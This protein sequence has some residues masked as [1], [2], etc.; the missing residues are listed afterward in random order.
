MTKVCQM[1]YIF[2]Y[3]KRNTGKYQVVDQLPAEAM[4]VSDYAAYANMSQSNIYKKIA[5]NKADYKIVVFKTMNFVVPL[6]N[7]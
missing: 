1:S 2:D 4:T 6:T 5:R 3:M 7:N